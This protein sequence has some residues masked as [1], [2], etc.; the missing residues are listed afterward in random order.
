MDLSRREF[1]KAG[2]IAG[3]GASLA[4]LA[5]PLLSPVLAAASPR[6]ALK[7]IEHVIV[8]I[9]ENRS[10]DHYYGTFPGVQGF[11]GAKASVLAQ[12]GY[13]AAGFGGELMPFHLDTM[14][15]PQCFPDIT[16]DW[17]PQHASWN[18]GAM[19]GFVRA[20]LAADGAAAGPATMGY[21]EQP[22]IPFYWALAQAYT[23]C[24]AYHCS[25]LGPTYPNRLLSVSGTLDPD[26]KA[27]GPLLHTLGASD[28]SQYVGRFT[29]T[30]MFEQLQAKGV[31]WKVYNGTGGGVLDNMLVFFKQFQSNSALGALGLKPTYP[32]DFMTDLSRGSLPAVSWVLLGIEETEHP[33]YSS[34]R[35]G[36]YA[37]RQMLE[38]IWSKPKLWAKTA[39][40]ITWDENGGF[41]DHVN[42]PTPAPGTPG[43]Y[44]TV[45]P[46]PADA[47]GVAGPIG[48]GFRVPMLI[49][50]PF[51]RGG[52]ISSDRFDHTSILRFLE[53]RFGAEVPN[54]SAWRRSHTG[55]LTSAFNFAAAPVTKVPSLPTVSLSPSLL[56]TGGCETVPP[57]PV[58][59]PANTPP[60][61][62]AGK[63]RRP[64]GLK[65]AAVRRPGRVPAVDG[66]RL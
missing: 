39:V 4:G 13:P 23:L 31:S 19:N 26:G 29:W 49:V 5:D 50:S 35:I 65:A 51:S 36:E 20:H 21:Y 40:F 34:A 59:V 2:A 3:A 33:G 9:Q 62:R 41:F 48:L 64:S 27:G 30:T 28:Y 44:V 15:E 16:H 25:A 61:Q 56:S 18:G 55:D 66:R 17:G 52:F 10:F 38:T 47:S 22:D 42:P 46:L 1:L 37:T 6:S 11:A 60:R 58:A 24:D 8:L 43:E 53:T 7:D 54:L 45:N 63:P 12:P 14:G 32:T 57:P